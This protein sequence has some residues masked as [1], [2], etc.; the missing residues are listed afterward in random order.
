VQHYTT[1][2]GELKGLICDFGFW[3]LDFGLE[4]KSARK[5][6]R[7]HKKQGAL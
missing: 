1:D 2:E 6:H 7:N 3:V 5:N 4:E